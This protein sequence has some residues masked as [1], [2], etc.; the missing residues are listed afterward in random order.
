MNQPVVTSLYYEL[1]L[2][3]ELDFSD[4]PPIEREVSEFKLILKDGQLETIM[5]RE[6]QTEVEARNIVE[7][8]LR[9]WELDLFLNSGRKEFWFE[10]KN[11]VVIDKNPVSKEG[12]VIHVG[13]G[14]FII[15]GHE[16]TLRLTRK[17]YP[18]PVFNLSNS[19][20]VE[21]LVKRYEGFIKRK[22][23]LLSMAYFCLTVI[24]S[25]NDSTSKGITKFNVDKKVLKKLGELT[26]KRGDMNE[27]RKAKGRTSFEPL[28]S[29]EID[30]ITVVVRLLIR[31]KA[32]YDYDP[33]GSYSLIDMSCLP[34]LS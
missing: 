30:W 4:P 25:G 28:T 17:N 31:R 8:Y 18:I 29:K 6:V 21:S 20:D 33:G 34:E 10:F 14:E 22:E 11:S 23:P 27:S 24:E 5:K 9:S 32:E 7:P 13:V 19:P 15:A 12:K 1:K 3:P 2:S 16:V 26:S